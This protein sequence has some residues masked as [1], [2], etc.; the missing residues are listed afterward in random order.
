MPDDF[1]VGRVKERDAKSIPVAG[2]VCG[3]ARI[4]LGL[5]QH[6]LRIDCDFL[7]FD[8]ADENSIHEQGVIGG[9]VLG[10]KFCDCMAGELRRVES[11]M[12]RND[13][14]SGIERVQLRI[15]PLLPSLPFRLVPTNWHSAECA[16]EM[17]QRQV[18]EK[19]KG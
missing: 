1:T 2:T 19:A 3:P 13:L 18:F 9:T 17:G 8:D 7:G 10:G 16:A 5:F 4:T 12:P 11:I 6:V 15:N 14:P